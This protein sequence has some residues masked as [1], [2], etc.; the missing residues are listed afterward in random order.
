[1]RYTIVSSANKI[2]HEFQA[3]FEKHFAPMYQARPGM[4]LPIIVSYEEKNMV[5]E[6]KWGLAPYRDKHKSIPVQLQTAWVKDL[7]KNHHFRKPIRKQ[8]CLVPANCLI[9]HIQ[10]NGGKKPYV[11]Y[12]KDEKLFS[13]AGIWDFRKDASTGEQHYFFSIIQS[14]APRKL[15]SVIKEFPVIV[16][17]GQR[18]SYLSPNTP[19]SNIMKMLSPYGQS[20]YNLYPISQDLL[21]QGINDKSVLKP[22]GERYFPEYRYE[23]KMYVKLE[24]MGGRRNT[25]SHQNPMTRISN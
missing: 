18:R 13:I 7:V 17:P 5:Y 11:F 25:P 2:G 20:D 8:R 21:D 22:I 10:N 12:L 16:S 9:I 14:V 4:A 3:E 24:G 1:M 6:Y 15:Q 19:L 23:K